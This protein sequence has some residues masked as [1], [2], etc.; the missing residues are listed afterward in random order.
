MSTTSVRDDQ[1]P[2]GAGSA[3]AVA[4]IP[5]AS[6]LLLRESAS[7]SAP[8]EVLMIRRHERSSFVP[9][10]WV[11]PGGAVDAEDRAGQGDELAAMRLCAVRELFE[12]S[13]IWLGREPRDRERLRHDLLAG[14]V[15]FADLTIENEVA[16][17]WLVL[18]SRWITPVGAPKRFDTWFF[19][20]RSPENAAAT[21]EEREAVDVTWISPSD[22]LR[23]HESGEFPMVFPTIRNLE[24]IRSFGGID[25]LLDARRNAV[26]SVTRPLLVMKDGRKTIVLPDE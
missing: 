3:S 26:I 4:P 21:V 1:L 7:A 19:L 13:G 6:V 5:A 10:A 24:A 14:R 17:D 25:E 18:T 22:A 15:R 20:A 12:E 23:R 9:S 16:T 11:F 2:G 8:F